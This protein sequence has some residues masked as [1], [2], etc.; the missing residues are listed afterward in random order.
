MACALAARSS[1]YVLSSV[2]RLYSQPYGLQAT[3]EL[4][5]LVG[6]VRRHFEGCTSIAPGVRLV[7]GPGISVVAAPGVWGHG[8]H[9]V[10]TEFI[11]RTLTFSPHKNEEKPRARHFVQ[12]RLRDREQQR[13]A[14][15]AARAH[16]SSRPTAA[17]LATNDA[18]PDARRA[19][20]ATTS[21][22]VH[23][24]GGGATAECPGG[25]K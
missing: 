21:L 11:C 16:H 10:I 17:P 5:L 9:F 15:G 18:S 23:R 4:E 8:P 3:L 22:S 12:T 7:R 1:L 24:R 19:R 6:V 14:A 25:R 2:H 13:P 20:A